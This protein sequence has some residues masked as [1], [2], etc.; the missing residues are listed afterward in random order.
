[1]KRLLLALLVVGCSGNKD[2]G[3]ADEGSAP[4]IP[5]RYNV[6]VLGV[7]G[8]ESNAVWI[9]DWAQGRL[10]VTGAGD[11]VTFDFG[12]EASFAGRIEGDGSFRF[13]GNLDWMG[14]ELS[15]GSDG[16]ASVAPTDPGDG[17]QMLLTGE[18]RAVVSEPGQEECTSEGAFEATELVELE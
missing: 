14:A 16:L 5:G 17:S 9:N 7:V 11:S 8:C 18:I 3:E 10:D 4:D 15:I 12:D 13:S 2:S 1:M 6:A